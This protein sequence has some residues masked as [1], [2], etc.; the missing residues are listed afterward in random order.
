MSIN[1]GA[2]GLFSA[3]YNQIYTIPAPQNDVK[4]DNN[5]NSNNNNSVNNNNNNNN[6]NALTAYENILALDSAQ[7]GLLA[8][9]SISASVDSGLLASDLV[10]LSPQALDLLNGV[11]QQASPTQETAISLLDVTSPTDPL[12]QNSALGGNVNSDLSTQQQTQI[13]SILSQFSS[14][15]LDQT[16]LNEVQTA[17]TNVGIDPQQLSLQDLTLHA[18]AGLAP[19]PDQMFLNYQD[20]FNS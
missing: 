6:V 7:N 16:T 18:S 10:S 17:L 11:S 19:Y 15:P 14:A 3:G 13:A 2:G 5:S 4:A 8:G 9:S 12:V 20:E 1:V